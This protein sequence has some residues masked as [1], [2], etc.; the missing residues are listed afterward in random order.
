MD[1]DKRLFKTTIIYFIGTFGSKLL[2]F[3]LL[4]L[5]SKY[6]TTEQYGS[7]NLLTN[8]LPLIGPIFTLQITDGI[9]RFLCT[10]QEDDKSKYISNATFLM[11]IGMTIFMI[12]YIPITVILKFQNYTIFWLYFIMNYLA[13]FIQQILRGMKRNI[14]YSITG[15]LSTIIQLLFNIIMIRVLYEKSIL[16][17]TISGSTI[18]LVYGIFRTRFFK[19]LNIKLISKSVLKEMLQY[20][21]PLIPNQIS[22]WFNDIVGL[23]FLRFFIGTSA[24]GIASLS[25]KFP[26]II[27]TINSI[28]L[29]AW[30]ESTIYEYKSNDKNEY[31]SKG[32]E[33]F[34]I[35]IL[36]ASCFL[37]PAVKVY[38]RL[39]INQKYSNSIFYVP[40]MFTS[41]IFNALAGFLGTIYTASMKTK[42]AFYTTFVAAVSNIVLAIALIPKF[43]IYGYAFAN[44]LSYIIFF[45]VRKKSINKIVNIKE[46]IK[47]YI[48]PCGLFIITVLIYYLGNNK[49]N[50]IYELILLIIVLKKYDKQIGELYK[51]FKEWSL[52]K[53]ITNE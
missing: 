6:L 2:V 41:M 38:F 23:Y 5:Y 42:N 19:Y 34:L 3:F 35:C 10:S 4:P 29:L 39:F 33:L 26:T 48:F 36:L 46:D 25:N 1:R 18:I 51:R 50:I 15:V 31:Y 40:I 20:S 52:G 14:D 9:F 21:L 11:I 22:W 8:L 7:L 17:A 16:F 24:T 44:L 49:V 37:L 30:T 27:A 28:F 12:I 43:G 53:R 32:L 47:K 13:M 45:I